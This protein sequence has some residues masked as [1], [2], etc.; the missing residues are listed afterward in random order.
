MFNVVFMNSFKE[1][2]FY[3][4]VYAFYNDND[5]TFVHFSMLLLL[6]FIF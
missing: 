2:M 1:D 4:N 6:D 3:D 5:F